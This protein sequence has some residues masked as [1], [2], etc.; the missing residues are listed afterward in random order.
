M[1]EVVDDMN[2]GRSFYDLQETGVGDY[3]RD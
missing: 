1:E 3:F 2:E